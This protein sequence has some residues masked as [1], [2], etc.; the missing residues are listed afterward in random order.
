MAPSQIWWS[1]WWPTNHGAIHGYVAYCTY[2]RAAVVLDLH[3]VWSPI[4]KSSFTLWKKDSRLSWSGTVVLGLLKPQCRDLRR[5]LVPSLWWP[6]EYVALRV[7]NGQACQKQLYK[8]IYVIFYDFRGSRIFQR[9]PLTFSWEIW[10]RYLD[11]MN[12]LIFAKVNN[13]YRSLGDYR[14]SKPLIRNHLSKPRR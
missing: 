10:V 11:F 13:I 9:C 7:R 14:N 1:P 6:Y 2:W 3:P 4:I 12:F 8:G 5:P